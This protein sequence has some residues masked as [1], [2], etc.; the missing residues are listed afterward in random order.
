RRTAGFDQRAPGSQPP[1]RIGDG[2]RLTRSSGANRGT[3]SVGRGRALRDD[4]TVNSMP[5]RSTPRTQ[6]Q[7]KVWVGSQHA[8]RVTGREPS[9]GTVD[10]KM[11]APIETE[12]VKVDSRRR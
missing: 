6:V 10:E 5:L 3:P 8:D 9:Q 7:T 2:G 1:C 12:P 4:I 11:T